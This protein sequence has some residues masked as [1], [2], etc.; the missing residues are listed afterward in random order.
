MATQGPNFPTAASQTAEY[1][2]ITPWYN[3]TNIY[4]TDSNWATISLTYPPGYPGETEFI[5]GSN[6]N[7]SIPS[8]ATIDGLEVTFTGH[9]DDPEYYGGCYMAYVCLFNEFGIIL[10]TLKDSN[11]YPPV[12]QR[13]FVFDEDNTLTFG[14]PTDTWGG[15]AVTR[16]FLNSSNF[17]VGLSV[18]ID[19]G[20]GNTIAMKLNSMT[21]KVYY[22]SSV[23]THPYTYK[24][25]T[26]P[27]GTVEIAS[28]FLMGTSAIDYSGSPGIGGNYWYMGPDESTGYIILSGSNGGPGGVTPTFWRSTERTEASFVSLANAVMKPESPY[29][30]GAEA[31]SSMLAGN[32]WT[33]YPE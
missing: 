10:S 3:I 15:S 31:R 26:T 29:S 16:E 20:S 17:S 2:F 11:M 32:T 7:F 25:G 6:F 9:A 13:E 19:S 5:I 30:T 21:A 14:G 18:F 27:A 23:I 8:G 12:E 33:D 1:S 28:K 22:T 24:I 4:A